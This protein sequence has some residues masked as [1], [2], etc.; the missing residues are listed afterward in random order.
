MRFR[1]GEDFGQLEEEVQGL[2]VM[3]YIYIEREIERCGREE[4]SF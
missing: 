3:E 1:E 2:K 4:G